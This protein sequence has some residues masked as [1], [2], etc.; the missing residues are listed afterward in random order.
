MQINR[1]FEMV[2]LLLERETVTARDFAARFEV[3]TRTVYRDLEALS[4]AGIPV[5]TSRGR[6]GGIRLLPG[7]VLDKSLLSAREQADILTALQGLLAT[8]HSES[9]QVL[10]KVSGLFHKRETPWISIDFT[11]WDNRAK[12]SFELLRDA[13]LEKRE[14]C[15]SYYGTDGSSTFR[16]AR[17]VQLCF[18]AR[19]W[20]LSAYC[21]RRRAMRMFKLSRIHDLA[22]TGDIFDPIEADPDSAADSYP[23]NQEVPAE[24][25]E[26]WVCEALAA[27]VYDE[28][29]PEEIQ[30]NPDGS[31]LVT[32]AFPIDQ[33]AVGY[34]LSFGS[35]ARVLSPDYLR[36][37]I[38]TQARGIA[39][40]SF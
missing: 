4:A 18:K 40:Q 14:I 26:L 17:P 12:S 30:K 8:G 32:I 9:G 19:A 21:L 10:E 5:Y 34:M 13:I 3:S 22:L 7:F 39:E 35:G 25:I 36:E 37:I 6:G 11:G 27:R 16:A 1:L 15:F 33:W 2:Y 24:R 20:Y 31:F 23:W 29:A 38:R 28:F